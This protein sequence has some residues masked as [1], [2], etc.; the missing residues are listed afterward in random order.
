MR[1]P[2]SGPKSFLPCSCHISGAIRFKGGI[3]RPI[4]VSFNG[5]REV[6][7]G[8]RRQKALA[9]IFWSAA[10]PVDV[11][12]VVCFALIGVLSLL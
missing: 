10:L 6:G 5:G 11:Y 9:A 8:S 4:P 1:Y 7:A 12:V 2:G 3:H